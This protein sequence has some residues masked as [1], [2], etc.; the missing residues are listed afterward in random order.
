MFWGAMGLTAGAPNL[1]Y[2]CSPGCRN[3]PSVS[4]SVVPLNDKEKVLNITV[5]VF[6]TFEKNDQQFIV[7]KG[8]EVGRGVD[9]EHS[10]SKS[11][12]NQSLKN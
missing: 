5:I 11:S 4:V 1:T 9:R 10:G 2:L 3:I 6:H 8:A 12:L 7:K